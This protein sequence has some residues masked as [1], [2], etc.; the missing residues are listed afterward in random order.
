[1][2]FIVV[3]P[4]L[5]AISLNGYQHVITV[6]DWVID[7]HGLGPLRIGMSLGQVRRVLRDP[8]AHLPEIDAVPIEDCAYLDSGALPESIGAMVTRNH[9]VRIDVYKKES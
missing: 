3:L 4:F 7:L 8:Q 5:L 6:K 9:I 1:M 2:R